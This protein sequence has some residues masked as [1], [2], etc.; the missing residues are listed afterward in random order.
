MG[1]YLYN[2]ENCPINMANFWFYYNPYK[3]VP[4]RDSI[5]GYVQPRGMSQPLD[6]W[7]RYIFVE[8]S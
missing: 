4:D 5:Y 7:P 3:Y 6:P 1:G 2:Q 8:L